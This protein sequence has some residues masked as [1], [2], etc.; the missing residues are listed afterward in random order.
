[1]SYGCF[2]S[3]EEAAFKNAALERAN[4]RAEIE[5]LRIRHERA[6]QDVS[7]ACAPLD[8]YFQAEHHDDNDQSVVKWML[9]SRKR[10]ED[11]RLVMNELHDCLRAKEHL[12]LFL[13]RQYADAKRQYRLSLL[14]RESAEKCGEACC[15]PP[16][17]H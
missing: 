7:E 17:A 13:E 6:C 2:R 1:M 5:C 11:K 12:L 16:L 14:G 9:Q 10:Q 3:R 15:K 8:F 4:C